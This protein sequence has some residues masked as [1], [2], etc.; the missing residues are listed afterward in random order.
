MTHRLKSPENSLF[1]KSR[2]ETAAF[3]DVFIESQ[4]DD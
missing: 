4:M 2:F 1:L 3:F